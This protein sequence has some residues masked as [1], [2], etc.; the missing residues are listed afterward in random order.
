MSLPVNNDYPVYREIVRSP[1]CGG[2]FYA[3]VTHQQPFDYFIML[4]MGGEM[5]NKS[6][7]E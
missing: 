3:T 6:T 7:E 5:H 4:T 2:A 1:D